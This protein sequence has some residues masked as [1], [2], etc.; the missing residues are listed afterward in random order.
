MPLD[1]HTQ[2]TTNP[3]LLI[4]PGLNDS[5]PGHWQ[6]RWEQVLPDAGRVELGMWDDP[7][8][9]TWVNQ[10]NL[11]IHR[12]DRP[13]VLVAHSLGCLTVAWWAQYEQPGPHGPVIGA[14]L[15][16]PPDV[17]RPGLD[18]RLARFSACPRRELPFPSVVAASRNDPYCQ[19]RAAMALA[20]DWGS[21]F[22][23]VG[24]HG[25]INAQSN[26][27]DWPAGQ[28]LLA[29]VIAE[30]TGQIVP[31]AGAAS[32]APVRPN[33]SPVRWNGAWADPRN[34]S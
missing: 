31:G 5:G 22:V 17:D 26:L 16:A 33:W 23:D 12:A 1:R 20:R 11:A 2:S 13:V 3:L 30:A 32:D 4:I 7:H 27:G 6:T 25:H 9:N 21:T 24:D 19:P 34:Q 29:R 28:R 8:R 10:L 14:L 18:P 15:V